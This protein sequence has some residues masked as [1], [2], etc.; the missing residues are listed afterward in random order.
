MLRQFFYFRYRYGRDDEELYKRLKEIAT[1]KLPHI[2]KQN[3]IEV[4]DGS[5]KD[6]GVLQDAECYALLL[7]FMD[8][9]CMWE[10]GSSTPVLHEGWVG[11]LLFVMNRFEP[12]ARTKVSVIKLDDGMHDGNDSSDGEREGRKTKRKMLR[13]DSDSTEK[14]ENV[15]PKR[16][17]LQQ[18]GLDESKP[19]SVKSKDNYDELTVADKTNLT[20]T[21]VVVSSKFDSVVVEKT[22]RSAIKQDI[23]ELNVEKRE[24]CNDNY[25]HELTSCNNGDLK[26]E[27]IKRFIEELVVDQEEYSPL[28]L[29]LAQ[30]CTKYQLNPNYLLNIGSGEPFCNV[31]MQVKQW[32]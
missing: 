21:S 4:A 10:E 32:L 1:E 28:L 13:R 2:V 27:E 8:G 7:K 22:D 18:D 19:L 5:L 9:L 25:L 12:C 29:T 6:P 15:T 30:A 11:Q 16:K 3:V 23:K 31:S 24:S 14:K 20:D 26:E 17:K